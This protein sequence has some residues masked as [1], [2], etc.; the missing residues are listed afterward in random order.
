MKTTLWLTLVD[1]DFN[2]NQ[3]GTF[4][5][6]ANY[7]GRIVGLTSDPRANVF[8]DYKNS[9]LMSAINNLRSIV[10][11]PKNKCKKEYLKKKK[12]EL[13]IKM[14]NQR[15]ALV[16][17][18]VGEMMD[19]NYLATIQIPTG[20][21]IKLINAI[22]GGDLLTSGALEGTEFA[23]TKTISDEMQAKLGALAKAEE[24]TPPPADQLVPGLTPKVATGAMLL[25]PLGPAGTAAASAYLLYN[26]FNPLGVDTLESAI[27][28]G[29][30]ED[31]YG[32]S[33]T[34]EYFY[35]GDLIEIITDRVLNMSGGVDYSKESDNIF[36]W[37]GKEYDMAME[38]IR[39]VLGSLWYKFGADEVFKKINISDI[40]V[41][42]ALF[43]DW[44]KDNVI[45]AEREVYPFIAFIND[46]MTNLVNAALGSN[47][48]DGLLTQRIKVRKTFFSS[49][50]VNGKEPITTMAK[51]EF[52]GTF[53]QAA[54]NRESAEIRAE[55]ALEEHD[56]W[57][58]EESIPPDP[59]GSLEV[60]SGTSPIASTTEELTQAISALAQEE[61]FY[62]DGSGRERSARLL[63]SPLGASAHLRQGL[64]NESS[65]YH[66]VVFYM[67][68][69]ATRE[70]LMGDAGTDAGNGIYHM[71]LGRQCGLLKN[72]AFKKTNQ[73]Y[74]REARF[75]QQTSEEYN[76]LAQLS[77]VY[78][79]DFTMV[80][81]NIWIPGKRIYFDP[82]NFGLG[83]PSDPGSPAHLLGLGGYHVVTGV[84][85]FIE[86]GK[87]ETVVSTRWE[88]GGG[89]T[90]SRL[91]P[92]DNEVGGDS[93]KCEEE[94]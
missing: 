61:S 79:V 83:K 6:Q 77:N 55:L 5:L 19:K 82:A 84:K 90:A 33:V 54:A 20:A 35:L 25:A 85:S 80:G 74:L 27:E 70:K 92:P 88:T 42:L 65:H 23:V 58:V 22:N 43:L 86:S 4:T 7:M 38:N 18:I 9:D 45:D 17:S 52:A 48:F 49:A 93:S 78:D 40:P 72:A 39:I 64:T 2:I 73:Q 28:G 81:N 56:T 1:H 67:E 94:K 16:A 30:Y 71:Q 12:K 24:D 68:N 51:P 37:R 47:C 62:R 91:A 26:A 46:V 36:H 60:E 59:A 31:F 69:T 32:E 75:A 8:I 3:D 44:L 76:P 57:S 87:F 41:S 10:E 15:Q 34:F 11:D 50:G 13:G 89:S 29:T 14:K 21:Y 66:Y 63:Y 53:S